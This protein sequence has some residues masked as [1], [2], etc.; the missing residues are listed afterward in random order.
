MPLELESLRKAVESLRELLTKTEDPVFIKTLDSITRKGLRAGAILNFE[1]T[2]E[3]CWKFMKRWLEANLGSTYVD[4]V[5]KK[6]LFR[7]A[8]EHQL[9]ADAS[10]WCD[11]HRARNETSHAYAEDKAEEVYAMAVRLGEDSKMFLTRL[12]KKND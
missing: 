3:L 10:V 12:E 11:Y 4:G 9:I 1:F 6:E 7:L 5:S 2:Y 8:A